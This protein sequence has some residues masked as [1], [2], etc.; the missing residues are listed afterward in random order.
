M[1]EGVPPCPQPKRDYRWL[2]FA[3]AQG[4]VHGIG[5]SVT[6]DI[7]ARFHLVDQVISAVQGWLF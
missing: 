4:I 2:I 6:R 5:F 1:K 3:L 7:D